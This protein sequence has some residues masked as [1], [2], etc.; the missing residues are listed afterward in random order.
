MKKLIYFAIM[1]VCCIGCGSNKEKECEVSIVSCGYMEAYEYISPKQVSEAYNFCKQH[2]MNTKFMI[3]VNYS[4]ASDSNRFFVFSFE[5]ERL[6]IKSLCAHGCGLNSTPDKPVFS[7]AIGSNCSSLGKYEI[8]GHRRMNSYPENCFDLKGLDKTNSNALKRSI[9]IH[10]YWVVD[11]YQ[12]KEYKGLIPMGA[13]SLGCFTITHKAM[14]KLEKLYNKQ[15][16][17]NILLYAYTE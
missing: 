3:F 16:N 15:E 17:K 9:L 2:N 14:S 1:T 8:V 11:K 12:D 6:L 10:P 4:I 7:N 5:N 13:T